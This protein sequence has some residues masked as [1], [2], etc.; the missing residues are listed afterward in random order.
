MS[1]EEK[2]IAVVGSGPSGLFVVSELLKKHSSVRVDVIE[3][4]PV[5]FGLIRFGVAPDHPNTRRVAE[6]LAPVLRDDRVKFWGGVEVGR[7]VSWT[8]LGEAYHAVVVCTGAEQAR[9]LPIPGLE[10]PGVF[11]SIE[12]TGWTNGHPDVAGVCP[13]LSGETAV[14]VGNGNVALD[15]ARLLAKP[16]EDLAD[17]D[18][19]APAW[20]ALRHSRVKDIVVLGRRGPEQASFAPAMLEELQRVPGVQVVVASADVDAAEQRLLACD[21][22]PAPQRRLMHAWRELAAHVAE[23]PARRILF[24]FFTEPVALKGG[25]RLESVCIKDQAGEQHIPATLFVSAIGFQRK[26]TACPAEWLEHG[27]LSH[28]GSRVRSGW[29]IS[30]WLKRGAKGLIGH[31][32]A[33]AAETVHALLDDWDGLVLKSRLP[34]SAAWLPFVANSGSIITQKELARI[35]AFERLAGLGRGRKVERCWTYD[36]F[37]KAARA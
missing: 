36:D 24:R 18:I 21:L 19:V 4:L 33:D 6:V 10:L 20:A 31:N 27:T 2:H 34:A 11:S 32:K 37:M 9:S 35:E 29:Y 14:V 3:R 15:V 16:A 28:E 23:Q 5:P 13:D 1:H 30:G 17:T 25:Q 12:W 7:D 8:A 26:S 22:V